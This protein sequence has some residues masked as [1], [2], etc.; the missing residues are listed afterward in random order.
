MKFFLTRYLCV[1]VLLSFAVE[2]IALDVFVDEDILTLEQAI[3]LTR[4]AETVS[5][6]YE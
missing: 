5:Q 2:S 3:S 1:P 6:S 4:N